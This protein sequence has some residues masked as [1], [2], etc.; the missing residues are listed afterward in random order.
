M[1]RIAYAVLMLL[2]TATL[3]AQTQAPKI[4]F[5]TKTH[6]FGTIK[7]ADGKVTY[8]FKFNN[9]GSQPLLLKNV[10][11]SCGCTT[12][13]W[14]KEPILPNGTGSIS[15]TYDP[16]NRPGAFRKTITVTTNTDPANTYLSI[17]GKVIA[18]EKTVQEIY[19]FML[20]ALRAKKT[21]LSFFNLTNTAKNTSSIMVMNTTSKP[22]RVTFPN[23]PDHITA[24]SVTIPAGK[25]GQ[26]V[27]TYDASKKNDWGYVS[28][29][30]D[31]W[32]DGARASSQLKLS[33]TIVEDFSKLSEKER[34]EAPKAALSVR[35]LDFGTVQ[36]GASLT[37]SF[38]IK[39]TGK[40]PLLIHSVKS[41]STIVKCQVD[42]STL[43]VGESA[44]VSITLDTNRTR[45]RQYKTINVI[46]N[47]PSAPNISFTLS[48]TVQ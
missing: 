28:D 47:D 11:A 15:V 24:P 6:N 12:P 39:N 7:E 22:V 42:K 29:V 27:F 18:R 23:L 45:G 30:I 46:T 37:R 35:K 4:N 43:A 3:S 34:A 2:L 16:R 48:G 14:T 5:E 26:L 41:T 31:C 9:I 20:G 19:P 33:A 44:Q 32:V 8:V 40:S 1:K 17:Q 21:H 38:T 36:K 25:E 10:R 13:Q